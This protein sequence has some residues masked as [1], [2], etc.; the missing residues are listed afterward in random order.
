M[1]EKRKKYSQRKFEGEQRK[2]KGKAWEDA[3]QSD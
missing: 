1:P 2:Q 3:F